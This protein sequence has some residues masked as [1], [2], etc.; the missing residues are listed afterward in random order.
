MEGSGANLHDSGND[1]QVAGF[2][3]VVEM[4]QLRNVCR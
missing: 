3:A 4:E 2:V 1:E